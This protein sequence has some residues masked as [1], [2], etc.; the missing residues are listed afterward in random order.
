VV[1]SGRGIE[2]Q[3]GVHLRKGNSVSYRKPQADGRA[4]EDNNRPLLTLYY[5]NETRYQGGS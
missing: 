1:A 4:H 2:R 5:T 3:I